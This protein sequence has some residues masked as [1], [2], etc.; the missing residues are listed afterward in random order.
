MCSAVSDHDACS[1]PQGGLEVRAVFLPAGRKG[2][3][4]I[5]LARRTMAAPGWRKSAASL[6]RHQRARKRR[7]K[8]FFAT[9][10]ASTGALAEHHAL[11]LHRQSAYR[12]CR[13]GG[14]PPEPRKYGAYGRL[15]LRSNLDSYGLGLYDAGLEARAE[16]RRKKPRLAMRALAALAD[17]AADGDRSRRD[18]GEIE[19]DGA[20]FRPARA[21][22]HE[23]MKFGPGNGGERRRRQA[24]RRLR[25]GRPQMVA[26]DALSR[27]PSALTALLP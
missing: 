3:F 15:A 24:D 22:S 16:R 26:G 27:G 5:T 12:A 1:A 25:Q 20:L 8:I 18:T 17:P 21:L 4:R 11:A 10:S 14:S 2:C 13:G 23:H 6:C 19:R 9:N 7:A